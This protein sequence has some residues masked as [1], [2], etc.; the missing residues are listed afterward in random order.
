MDGPDRF[1]YYWHDLR[2]E[3]KY[4]SKRQNGGGSVMVFAAIGFN[5]KT[6]ICYVDSRLNSEA[7]VHIL[8][9]YF[10]PHANELGGPNFEFQQDNA[11]CHTSKNTTCWLNDQ[12]VNVMKWPS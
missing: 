7:Y 8:K 11:P 1:T 2:K 10:L 9:S 12:K 6:N 4:F 5:G 3:N